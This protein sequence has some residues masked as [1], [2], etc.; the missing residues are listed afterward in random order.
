MKYLKIS[1][2][3]LILL[4]GISTVSSHGVDVTADTMVVAN[5]SNGKMVKSIAESNN[6]NISV[7]KFT[8]EDE[9]THILEHSINNTNKRIL[10]TAYQETAN[11]FLKKHPDMS[12]RIIVIDNVNDNTTLE[13]LQNIMNVPVENVN[14]ENNFGLPLTIGIIIGLLIGIGCGAYIM[15]R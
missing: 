6:I 14:S 2:L 5:D 10:F 1:I 12:N 8:S 11:D 3:L 9:V 13:G 7:Y 4:L 15:K